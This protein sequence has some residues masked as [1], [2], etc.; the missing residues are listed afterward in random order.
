[1]DA[2]QPA[3]AGAPPVPALSPRQRNAMM[4]MLVMVA[5]CSAMDRQVVATV[6]EPI[7]HE[8][9]LSDAQLGLITG[10][11]FS[12][13]NAVVG[14]PVGLLADRVNRRN[15]LACALAA[16]SVATAL[17]GVAQS[18]AQ[19]V[20]AR[21]AVGGAEAGGQSP[22]LSMVSDLYPP[23]KRATAVSFYYMAFPIGGMLAAA[24]GG[25]VAQDFGWRAAL[26]VAAVPGVL[27]CLAL[28][29]FGRHPPRENLG[30]ADG[31]AEP[32]PSLKEVLRYVAKQRSM[33][34]LQAGLALTT[35]MVAGQAMFVF[36]FFM[37]YHHMDIRAVGSALGV[38][39]GVLGIASTYLG[40][41][42]ADRLGRHDPRRR[43]WVVV[44]ALSVVTPVVLISYLVPG[45][46][47]FPLYL[48]HILAINIWLGPGISAIQNL[49]RPAMRATVAA[50]MYTINGVVGFG[51]G[52]WIVGLL[53]DLL[54]HEIGEGSLRVA[55]ILVTAVG[56]WAALHFHL[57]TRTLDADLARARA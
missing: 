44:A 13:A 6:I 8:F 49:S 35:V 36:S 45:P 5:A 57:A 1:M 43:L 28:L 24:A 41:F 54:K 31:E 29:A 56:F 37:R 42:L 23:E 33:L 46:V 27:L 18:F 53:S 48:S 2:S 39:T 7:K 40:G 38:A 21:M 51:L 20:L 22:S 14:I 32:A 52:P 10:L 55:L 16:W 15:V 9:G 47:A 4:V 25:L 3:G 11:S 34:H 12:A 30:R 17:C 50:I 19:L 26:L